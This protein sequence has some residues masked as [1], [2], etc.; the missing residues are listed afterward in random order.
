MLSKD[1]GGGTVDLKKTGGGTCI[2]LRIYS[3]EDIICI[4][5]FKNW[6]GGGGT[7][8]RVHLLIIKIYYL[9]YK[10]IDKMGGG[11]FVQN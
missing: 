1:Q 10:N 9:K 11:Y 8:Y 5:C 6:G 3:C 4:K 7:S 2:E